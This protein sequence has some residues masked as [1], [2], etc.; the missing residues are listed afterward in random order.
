MDV[1]N[2]YIKEIVWL[3]GFECFVVFSN[4]FSFEELGKVIEDLGVEF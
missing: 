4:I 3:F 2:E 1:F